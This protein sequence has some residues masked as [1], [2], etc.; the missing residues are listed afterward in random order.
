[1]PKK[2][3]LVCEL[4]VMTAHCKTCPFKPDE[5]GVW[6]DPRLA[7]QVIERTLF[8]AQ[9][10]CHGTEGPNREWHN[11]C[12]GA[13]DHNQ[14]IYERLGYGD[15]LLNPPENKHKKP[16]IKNVKRTRCKHD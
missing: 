11:R 16:K 3:P 7:N 12:K 14:A 9:Q 1:M 13:Y 15:L 5:H 6:Q 2:N 8:Q 4:P 10:V